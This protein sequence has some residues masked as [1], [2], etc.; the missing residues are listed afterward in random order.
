MLFMVETTLL[1]TLAPC[2]ATA[3]ASSASV[4][5]CNAF[6]ALRRTVLVSSSMDAA[7]STIEAD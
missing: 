7:V 6:S 3:E 1:T 4:F 5:A 2:F